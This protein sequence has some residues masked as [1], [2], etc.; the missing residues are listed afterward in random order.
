MPGFLFRSS[1]SLVQ[2]QQYP[3]RLVLPPVVNRKVPVQRQNI[4]GSKLIR[5]TNQAGV[6]TARLAK[7]LWSGFNRKS[8][9]NRLGYRNQCG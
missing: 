6:G 9:P 4:A 1:L 5:Q 2:R 8:Q 3:K 7:Y